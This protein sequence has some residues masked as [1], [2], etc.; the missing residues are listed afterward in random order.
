M[1]KVLQPL[2]S[3]HD[4]RAGRDSEQLHFSSQIPA[5]VRDAAQHRRVGGG[6]LWAR[7]ARRSSWTTPLLPAGETV[8]STERRGQVKLN[9]DS[10]L[11]MLSCKKRN[12]TV[13]FPLL[14]FWWERESVFTGPQRRHLHGVSLSRIICDNSHITHVPANPFSRTERPEDMLACSHPLIPH[15][16]LS[17]WKEP[18][19]GKKVKKKNLTSGLLCC[20]VS[21]PDLSSRSQLWSD[22]QDSIGLLSAVQLCDSI[23]VSLWIQAAGIFICQVWSRQPT[24]EPQTP[25][26]SRYRAWTRPRWPERSIYWGSVHHE[27][28]YVCKITTEV[29]PQTTKVHWSWIVDTKVIFFWA[30]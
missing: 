25:N 9:P 11:W 5:P 2:C 30:L 20:H 14:R 13:L 1:E 12:Q 18:D 27:M 26:M 17:P 6:H 19:T 10:E 22:T 29:T 4:I 23:S 16:D 21:L 28:F 3:Q 15:L 8:Q 24:V 7:S